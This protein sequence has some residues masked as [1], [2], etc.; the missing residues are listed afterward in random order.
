LTLFDEIS[1]QISSLI[2]IS[3]HAKRRPRDEWRLIAM[4]GGALA[5]TQIPNAQKSTAVMTSEALTHV[6]RFRPQ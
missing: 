4:R 6:I 5:T 3:F 1:C 2:S